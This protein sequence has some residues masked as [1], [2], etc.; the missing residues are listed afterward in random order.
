MICAGR[1]VVSTLHCYVGGL[2]F[3]PDRRRSFAQVKLWTRHSAV[4]S[5]PALY[6]AEGLGN[7][8]ENWP[9]PTYAEVKKQE[10]MNAFRTNGCQGLP[11]PLPFNAIKN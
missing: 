5:R 11:L 1:V 10:V 2:G 4:M 3:N 9:P 7:E 8:R 6:L